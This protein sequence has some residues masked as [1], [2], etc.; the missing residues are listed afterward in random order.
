[1]SAPAAA[2]RAAKRAEKASRGVEKSIA[3]V[4]VKRSDALSASAHLKQ[5]F[6]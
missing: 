1:M 6:A 4:R 3:S 5:H 2:T